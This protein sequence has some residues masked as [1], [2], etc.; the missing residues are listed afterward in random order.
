MGIGL[1]LEDLK[2]Q[3]GTEDH[4]TNQPMGSFRVESN[5]MVHNQSINQ[6]SMFPNFSANFY[7]KKILYRMYLIK[8]TIFITSGHITP[9]HQVQQ[10]IIIMG[11]N[12]SGRN[13]Y[14][15]LVILKGA[16][17][18]SF[19]FL[20]VPSLFILNVLARSPN[21]LG[22]FGIMLVKQIAQRN[23]ISCL[24]LSF[25]TGNLPLALLARFLKSPN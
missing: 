15:F 16:I 21:F 25:Q 7:K 10:L 17:L 6:T 13:Y 8:Y 19:F 3:L 14:Q 11:K 20:S 1:P 9:Y 4:G 24:N 23:E 2:N 12:E 5:L 22:M 18:Q